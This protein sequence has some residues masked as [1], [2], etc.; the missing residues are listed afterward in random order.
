[1]GLKASVPS[2]TPR[3]PLVAL[4]IEVGRNGNSHTAKMGGA[5][6]SVSVP[7]LAYFDSGS[8]RCSMMDASLHRRALQ[9]PLS[10]SVVKPGHS[11]LSVAL[12]TSFN[13]RGDHPAA[14]AKD[15]WDL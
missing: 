10:L 6:V 15:A 5:A 11:P 8:S 14:R 9:R 13:L 12:M 4:R 2:Q 1:M 3:H 7:T